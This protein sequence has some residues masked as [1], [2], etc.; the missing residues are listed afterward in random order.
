VAKYYRLAA[1]LLAERFLDQA[2]EIFWGLHTVG[3][4]LK[5][6]VEILFG[7]QPEESRMF[8]ANRLEADHRPFQRER[9]LD[10][11]R[12]SGQTHGAFP[13]WT[14]VR[15]IILHSRARLRASVV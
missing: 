2:F 7:G 13:F 1:L 14:G 3:D 5:D 11:Q 9:G 12:G 8:A 10:M 15:T 4:P 6:I